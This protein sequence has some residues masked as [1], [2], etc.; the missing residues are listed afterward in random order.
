MYEE[1]RRGVEAARRK[2]VEMGD[3]LDLTRRE[4]R[5]AEIEAAMA[6]SGFWEDRARAQGLVQ[7]L[8]IIKIGLERYRTLERVAGDLQALLELGEEAG[9]ESM[10]AETGRELAGLERGIEDLELTTLLNGEYDARH[11]ILALHPGAGGTDAQDWV[12]ILGRMYSRWAEEH[13]YQVAILDCLPGE[14]GG[15]KSLTLQVAGPNAYGFLKAEKGVHRLVRISPFDAS[16]RRHTSFASVDVVPEI[17]DDVEVELDPEELRVDTFRSGGAGGQHVNK[18]DSAVRITHLPTGIVVTCQNERS[19]H[20]NRET[21]LRILKSRL[22]EVRQEEQEEELARLRGE[23]R[24][25]AWGSQIRSYVFQPYTLV[26]DHRTGEERGNVQA[27][28]DG[29]LDGFIYAYLKQ[30]A[31]A[32]G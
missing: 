13:D 12:E 16:G 3:S 28:L 18:T 32:N 7:E 27:V 20:A 25:I 2:L 17:E 26:K 5:A 30:Q 23:Q 21:A 22:L 4:T 29:D 31:R 8:R 15:L 14:E 11:A 1:V 9:D 10:L 6:V 24:E 19:Q